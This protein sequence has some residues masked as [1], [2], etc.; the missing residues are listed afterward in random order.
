[1]TGFYGKICIKEYLEIEETQVVCFGHP[2]NIYFMLNSSNIFHCA[3]WPWEKQALKQAKNAFCFF[4][5]FLAYIWFS[6]GHIGWNTSTQC[7]SNQS[8]LKNQGPMHE[9]FAKKF[10]GLAVLEKK[11]FLVGHFDFSFKYINFCSILM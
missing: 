7:P 9:I 6:H 3:M 2:K 10:W 4:G 8:I 5:P 1:M 11:F